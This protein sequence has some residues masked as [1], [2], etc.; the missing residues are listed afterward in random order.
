MVIL[1]LIIYILIR[2]CVAVGYCV[3][4]YKNCKNSNRKNKNWDLY[5][6]ESDLS[7]WSLLIMFGW[8]ILIIC[9]IPYLLSQIPK[10]VIK[11][12]YKIND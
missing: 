8:P 2:V 12:Y 5:Y 7:G 10:I 9:L 1:I 3:F 11:K 6:K 4:E